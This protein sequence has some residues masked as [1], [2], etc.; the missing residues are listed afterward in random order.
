LPA[1]LHIDE[2]TPHVDWGSGAVRLLTEAVEWPVS[3]RPRRVGVSS[4]GASGTNA[5]LILEH[6]PEEATAQEAA[7]SDP[8]GAVP[9]VLSARTPEALHA[10]ATALVAHLGAE[11]EAS[12]ADIGWSLAT[13]R[14]LFEHRAVVLGGDRDGL[15][16]ALE[17]L[18]GDES[19]P[20]VVRP[21]A[22]IGTAGKAVWMFSGQ[23]SQRLG[24]G[25][26]LYAR[27]PVF[28]AAFD[29]VCGHLDPYLEHP[30]REVVFTGVAERPGLL[31]HTTYAQAGL[32]ALHIALARLL[33]SL[34]QT[35]DVV[36]GHSIGEVAAAQVAGVFDL[37][38]ACRLVAARATLM[39]DLP[40]GGG[41]ASIEA[42][43]E[44]LADDLAEFDGQVGVAALNTPGSTVISGPFELVDRV[45]AA[46]AERGRKT[47]ALT[48]S[49]AFHS[50]LMDP[51]LEPFTRA[52]EG[53][54]YHP[55]TIPVLSNL[56][57]EP[58][59]DLIATPGYW[60]RHIRRPV[61][62]H[63]AVTHIAPEAG[64]FL[65]LGPDPVL[66]SA[67]QHTLQHLSPGE[68]AADDASGPLVVA[69]L[70]RKRADGDA[71]GH[72]LAQL[73]VHGHDVAWAGWFPAD[74]APRPVPLPTYAFQRERY[75][76]PAGAGVGDVAAA[77]LQRVEHALLPAAVDLADG[78]LL[79][80]GRVTAGGSG[81]WLA[82][83]V[84][85]GTVLVPGAALVEWA[86]RAADEAGCG[87]V[88]ELALQVP[89]VL[90]ASGG[91]RVQVVVGAATEDGRRDV[92]VYSRPDRHAEPGV[93]AGWVCHAE[94]VLSP[95]TSQSPV[96][97]PG[98]W[99]PA[100]AEPVRLDGFYE[101]VAASGYVYGPSFQGLRAVW[102]DGADVLA[103]V[104]LPEVVG[105]RDGFGIHP[106]LLDAAL[107]PAL[108]L[109]RPGDEPDATGTATEGR[110]DAQVWLPFVW[111]GVSLW[112]SG[113]TTVRVRLSPHTSGG[114]GEGGAEG[115]RGLTVTVADAVGA[116][117][118][119]VDALVMR[120]AGVDQ[121]RA[122][123]G[124][125]Q[126]GLFTLDWTPLPMTESDT[127]PH[128][129]GADWA[130][131]GADESAAL[132][133]GSARHLDLTALTAA[134]DTGAAVP[135]VALAH[136]T[137]TGTPD[138]GLAQTERALEL[139]RGWL[140]E[141]RLAESRL[142]IVTRG[143][144]LVTGADTP[145]N[146]AAV[147]VPGAAVCG[148]VRSAQAENPGR[149]LLVDLD[150]DA[151][152]HHHDGSERTVLHGV[153]HAVEEDEPQIAMRSG[154]WWVPRLM[155]AGGA[156]SGGITGPVGHP[157]WRLELTGAA[158]VENVRPV[159]C[160]EVLEPLAPGQVR[161]AVHAAG[162][163]FRD[164]LI[165]LGMVPGQTGLGGEGAGVVVAVGPDVVGVAVGD[166][167]MGVFDRAFGPLVVTDARLVA[168]I[169]V[170]WSFQQA[171]A[172]PVAYLTA[173]Y[174]LVELGGLG[175]DESVLIHAATGGVGTAAV[176]IA[177][178]LGAEVY[179]TSGPGKHPVLESMGIDAAHRASSRDLDFE[180]TL[181]EATGGRGVDVVLNSLAGE[182]IDASLRLLG[183]GGR[184]LEMGK[185]DLRDPEQIAIAHP[186]VI[187]RIYDLITDAGPDLIGRML[188]ELVR[189]FEAGVLEPLPVRSWP[190]GRAREALRYLSQAR[191]TGKLVLDV[192]APVDPDGTVLITGGTGTL[193]GLVAEHLV[194][195]GQTRHLTLVSRR[196]Y[197]APGA[198]E[199]TARLE[200]LGAE[201]RIVAADVSDA[202]AV[203]ELVAGVDPVH[204]L[205]GVI[206][207]AGVLD[208]AV[209]T[210]QTPE[211]LARV[212]A[213][214]A[215]AAAHLHAATEHLRL[216]MFV[217]FSSAAGVMGSPGQAN[218]AAA[219]AYC[220]ALA[221]HRQAAGLPGVSVAWGLWAEASD[222]TGDLTDAD[223][224]RMSR[225][226]ATPMSSEHALRLLDAAAEHGGHHLIAADMD[227]RTLAAQP[228]DSL[229]VL[230]RALVATSTVGA[231]GR[232]TA[233][234]ADVRPA[235]WSA[236]L[237]GL[238][239]AERHRAVLHL[240]RGHVAAVLGHT[241]TEAVQADANFKDLG[242]DS[243]TAV[244]L[245]NRLAAATGLR[246]PAA[247]VFD[248]P[249]AGVLADYLL[250]RIAPEEGAPAG[251]DRVDPVLNEL[252]RL[253]ATLIGLEVEDDA[254]LTVTARLESLLAKWKATRKPVEAA[255]DKT[256][257]E[258]LESASAAQVLDFIDNELG[259][260]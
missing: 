183:E 44:E 93:D 163:N 104:A 143:A 144:A 119:T 114:P 106:A 161:V 191:H 66:A 63:P 158:T 150:P 186:G 36:L 180:G 28:A 75:W 215:T 229:P 43:A 256:A 136:F 142:V 212:W 12:A 174:G 120:P 85:A 9:W 81:G 231:A 6:T 197:E 228:V 200:T 14:T 72:T 34:G 23:G 121:L 1:S 241:D 190:L 70:T 57:G 184:F 167:V 145:G 82:E 64:V 2:P 78:G 188:A 147:D 225:S 153:A 238:S 137:T 125:G 243:L 109:D 84:M 253:E 48:V 86:L 83:H 17:A 222:M 246:L 71:L 165:S 176:R 236:R 172:A 141:P 59:D 54:T 251:P 56:T 79:L 209:V 122:A 20:S 117:V 52:I 130:E 118:L 101:R 100:G 96:E 148:L 255:D 5:H 42:T 160:P 247:L 65:E 3:D 195:T 74:P 62:F 149:F 242:F 24:M 128:G 199:L 258:R 248:Y 138:D 111:N 30:L 21:G 68:P 257:A 105:D 221:A 244:E 110:D 140:A 61:L 151:E 80:T 250:E 47:K 159:P 226:G 154:R 124:S 207:A 33:S 203:R 198:K 146:G 201:V 205:T 232:R 108:L 204:P 230:L 155:R 27:F 233:A 51:I 123:G 116:P 171:A 89:L 45:R 58:A 87:G 55:P 196:G 194:R 235:D 217:M 223:L 11:P 53:L 182:F 239:P 129:D 98:A 91:L 156:S 166:R 249:E 260:S 39:G 127:D 187:Y 16:T 181:R 245:R 77:G 214:K 38:D 15:L 4:F 185:T 22:G 35:P 95:P 18:A 103:E 152:T 193:G 31:D 41:M 254:S 112:A 189:L 218:Y 67:T 115:E 37:A 7:V 60:A 13:T 219:N 50:P 102:R 208:D 10:Q 8:V 211:R 252:A 213:A 234:T 49:H 73:H 164:A 131:L 46:W 227:V 173:W 192:P 92:R 133:P 259:V 177:R 29:E 19:H 40:A 237:A 90:P 210:S 99:P 206:H 224:A 175:A 26:E 157:A 126:D 139:V 88:E 162:I 32:F 240:V 220:D 135:S 25:A 69:T 170:G 202:E 134:L 113:A 179:A 168:P 94:G 216:G 132:V 97:E 169:P 107:H 76:L 178:H